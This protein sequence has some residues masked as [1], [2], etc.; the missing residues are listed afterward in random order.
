MKYILLILFVIGIIVGATFFFKAASGFTSQEDY[1][2]KQK[3]GKIGGIIFL[4][5]IIGT[6]AMAATLKKA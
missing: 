1:D 3:W 6:G 2:K 5:S 4:V